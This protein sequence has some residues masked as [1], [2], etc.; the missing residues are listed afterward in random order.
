MTKL[1]SIVIPVYNEKGNIR[2]LYDRIDAALSSRAYELLFINDGSSDG[3]GEEIEGIF[4]HNPRVKYIEFSRNF[5][6]EMATSAGIHYAKGDAVILIDADLQHPPEILPEFIKRW[7]NGAEMVVGVRAFD[8]HDGFARHLGSRLFYRVMNA[9]G[10]TDFVPRSTDFRLIDRKVADEFNK[11]TEK[12]RV[13]RGILD[14]LGFKKEYLTFEV[15]ERN[16]GKESYSKRKLLALALSA[17]V[18]HST[19]PLRLVGYLGLSITLFS[20][21]LGAFLLVEDIVLGDPLGLDVS[22]A[23]MV[24]VMILFLVGIMLMWLGLIAFYIF[25]IQ[26]E[27]MGRPMYIVRLTK[28]L[29]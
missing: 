24:S 14:W 29:K 20:A 6:K 9:I 8:K 22:G 18:S 19:F 3:S 1:I 12:N 21:A 11:F 16:T 25:T 26:G 4:S 5:G 15:G 27:V 2:A 10:D 7:E 13:T 17:V 28:N 23:A